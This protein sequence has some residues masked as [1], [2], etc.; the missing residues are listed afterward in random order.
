MSNRVKE[1]TYLQVIALLGLII[2]CPARFGYGLIMALS[3]IIFIGFLSLMKWG[4]SKTETGNTNTLILLVFSVFLIILQKKLLGLFSPILEMTLSFA[5]FFIPISS[6]VVKFILKNTNSD[7]PKICL[8]VI[9]ETSIF[10]LKLLGIYGLREIFAYGSISLPVRN[11]IK[12]FTFLDR[13]FVFWGTIPGAF[14][15]MA[16]ILA[17]SISIKRRFYSIERN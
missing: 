11:G 12:V 3:L 9:K 14:I 16:S 13:N 17:I 10:A 6:V 8:F 1:K 7:S 4:L 5:L 2:P 15:I